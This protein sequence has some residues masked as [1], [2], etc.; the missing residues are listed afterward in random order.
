MVKAIELPFASSMERRLTLRLLAYWEKLRAGQLMPSESYFSAD[1]IVDM[2]DNCFL[3]HT[4]RFPEPDYHYSHM[5]EEITKA[6]R[7]GLW[8]GDANG[9]VSPKTSELSVI[10]EQMV[11]NPKPIVDE[12][13]FTNLNRRMVRFR[14]CFLP[15]GENGKVSAIL[16]G[17]HFK[18]F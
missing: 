17:M 4:A 1:D 13:E 12:G 3:L 6:W 10:Y 14:R 5:G 9:L 8:E 7:G 11:A 2:W 18:V 16:G 15:L